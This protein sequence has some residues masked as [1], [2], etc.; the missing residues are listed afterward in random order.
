MDPGWGMGP[1]THLQKFNPE[2]LMSKG[3]SRTKSGTETE[4]KAIE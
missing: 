1:H 2:L 4:E 3:N